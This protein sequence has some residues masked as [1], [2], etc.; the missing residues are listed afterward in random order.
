MEFEQL[1]DAQIESL[2]IRMIEDANKAK[3]HKEVKGLCELLCMVRI[4][5]EKK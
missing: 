4:N 5:R 2:I 1:T 3:Q